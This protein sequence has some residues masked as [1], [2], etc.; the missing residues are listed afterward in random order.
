MRFKGG[1]TSGLLASLII[2][3]S[4]P[5]VMAATLQRS[6]D[7]TYT[8][9]AGNTLYGIAQEKHISVTSLENANPTIRPGRIYVGQR[10]LVP[11]S[12]PQGTNQPGAKNPAASSLPAPE[13]PTLTDAILHTAFGLRGIR[14]DWGGTSPSTGFDC[15]GFIQYIFKQHG[16]SLPRTASEQSQVGR[17]VSLQNLTPGDLMF[18]IDTYSGQVT[19][20]VTHVALYIGNGNVI[21]SS[22]VNGQG[23]IVIHNLLENPWYRTRY[24]GARDVIGT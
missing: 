24:F 22:S 15:S 11:T 8:V 4:P 20:Q 5:A 18:F 10:I 14:Y 13:T 19:D 21:E 23:V 2:V 1:F 12:N 16:I 9:K 17:P 6:H 7:E 3:L